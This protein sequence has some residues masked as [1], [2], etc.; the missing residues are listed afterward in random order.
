MRFRGMTPNDAAS[1]AHWMIRDLPVPARLGGSLRSVL[2]R[3][4]A[5]DLLRGEVVEYLESGKGPPILTAFGFTGFLSDTRAR[6]Y[7]AAPYPHFELELLCEAARNAGRQPFL[8]YDEIARANYDMGLTL[9]PLL[10]LQQPSDL[11]DPQA[12]ALLLGSQQS[13]IRIHRGYR[14]SRILKETTADRAGAFIAAGFREVCRLAPGTPLRTGG[15]LV[16][17]HVVFEANRSDVEKSPPG[18]AISHLFAYQPPCGGFT[19]SE[20]QILSW[21]VEHHTDE[22][23]AERLGITPAAVTLRWRSIYARIAERAPFVFELQPNSSHLA[24]GKEKRRR[25]IAFVS[26]HPEEIRPYPQF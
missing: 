3:L 2:A 12:R 16:Q 10:W 14:L 13:F 22:E 18:T 26:R 15:A 9:F 21:S 24:R 23:I 7:L 1:A 5:D 11:N 8:G 6:E 19:R 25:V 17:E 20:K 4:I